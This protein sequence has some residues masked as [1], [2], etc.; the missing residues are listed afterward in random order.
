MSEHQAEPR[1]T[2]CRT[3]TAVLR[4]SGFSDEIDP[5]AFYMF[6]T[7]NFAALSRH[8]G[9]D[10][11]PLW[12]SLSAR[13]GEDQRL[14]GLFL[15]FEESAQGLGLAVAQAH[16]VECLD[17][18][19]RRAALS[20]A[21]PRT[22]SE[23]IV[24]D[25][26]SDDDDTPVLESQD[27]VPI[28]EEDRKHAVTRLIVHALKV[29]PVGPQID[30][31]QLSY[32]LHSHF[33][34]FCDGRTFNFTPLLEGLRQIEGFQDRDAFVGI[35]RIAERLPEQGLQ[36]LVPPLDVSEEEGQ[37]LIA[38]AEALERAER[39]RAIGIAAPRPETPTPREEAIPPDP[40]ALRL[41]KKE[42]Q[43]R[44]YDLLGL[45]ARRWR[46]I[47][48]ALMTTLL[49]GGLTYFWVTR[50]DRV[51]EA[52]G[53]P[54]PLTVARL[55]AGSFVGVLDENQW[56]VLSTNKRRERI[57]AM[58]TALRSHGFGKDARIIDKK[59]Q[60]LIQATGLGRLRGS[61]FVLESPDGI[62]PPPPGTPT[63]PRKAVK[64]KAQ[65]PSAP[66]N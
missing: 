51:L 33:E 42:Q 52:A 2:I 29:T 28:L 59:G 23:A 56:Y 49:I 31:A 66:A 60:L 34:E 30:G 41:T 27:L 26:G 13:F 6:L 4:R 38:D 20:R 36:L 8:G 43:L 37:R 46:L 35:V 39:R 25:L 24:E 7:A 54:V 45:D 15:A 22:T 19:S 10:L 1:K 58:E 11:N 18:E 32:H 53:W 48:I 55:Q 3:L 61:R 9:L 65:G 17:T 14:S 21:F 12:G 62:E 57:A 44:K 40:A 16:A 5:K 64:Q 47:R 50:P 63:D